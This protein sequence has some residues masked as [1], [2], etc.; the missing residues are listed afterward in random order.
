M[1]STFSSQYDVS[2][3]YINFGNDSKAFNF[4]MFIILLIIF[5]I[6]IIPWNKINLNRK[7]NKE[8]MS[9]G[10]LTQLFAQD[11][12][13]VYLKSNVDK[14]ATGN[15]SLMWNEP[16][17][18]T[19]S[20]QNR[21]TPLSTFILPNTPMNPN[22]YALEASNSYVDSIRDTRAKPA[23]FTNPVLSL[24]NV[25]PV[26]NSKP[27][28]NSKSTLRK[29]V[30]NTK[31]SE[32]NVVPMEYSETL[33]YES[34]RNKKSNSSQ[35]IPDN[36]LPSSLPMPSNPSNPPNPYEL[37]NV[38]KQVAKTDKT[39]NNLP[40]M[41]Q[42]KPVDYLYQGYLDKGLYDINCLK[43]PAACGTWHGSSNRLNSG[44]VQPTK[45]VEYVNLDGNY[46][47]PDSYVGSYWTE[48]NF[49]IMRPI[50][51]MPNKNIA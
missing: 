38:A 49:D 20:F 42:W 1:D 47:F 32:S 26:K 22:P 10:T 9:G 7:E 30:S 51:F 2:E 21:G 29:T 33:N 16:T 8:A 46:F 45:A 19:Q 18:I 11:S 23:N 28:Q 31:A 27:K 44:F 25:L 4:F 40:P 48:P 24:K 3:P 17:K 6:I 41:T 50:Q 13:D 12:Q 15:F 14:I 36:I 43:D 34:V 35:T 39:A 5:F 37:A